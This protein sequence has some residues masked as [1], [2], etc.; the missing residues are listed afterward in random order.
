MTNHK[1]I[2]IDSHAHLDAKAF[3]SDRP[4][5]IQRA[6]EAGLRAVITI[7]VGESLAD[8][9]NALA[10]AARHERI[11][12]TVGIH[13]HDAQAIQP[14]WYR[15]IEALARNPKVVGI[16]ETGL[17]YH[18]MHSPKEVQR[19]AF[20]RFLRMGRHTGLPV[21]I[22]TREAD[23]DTISILR[24]ASQEGGPA[25]DG[26]VHCFSGDYPLARQV[27]DLG[28]HISFTGI[29][30]FPKA[31]PLRDVL[32][33]IPIERILLETDCPY[34][35]P[36]PYRGKRNEPARVVHVAETVAEV[37]GRPVEDV[38]GITSENVLRLFRLPEGLL[39]GR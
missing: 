11:F 34:L 19:D 15:K 39:E 18:Y 17:D 30:T 8:L 26:V 6:W 28:L 35:A 38:A 36:V 13:P 7:G 29:I 31:E 1:G 27:L 12:A 9:E 3:D 25:L 5:V 10:L 2:L 24:Q 22:H 20:L 21:V 23:E 32:R 14:E 16:G 33:K 37:H 4:Q